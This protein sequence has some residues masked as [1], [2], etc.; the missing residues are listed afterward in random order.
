[1]NSRVSILGLTFGE[2]SA[3]LADLKGHGGGVFALQ[4]KMLQSSVFNFYSNKRLKDHNKDMIKTFIKIIMFCK[5]QLVM[6]PLKQWIPRV[7]S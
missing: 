4:V 7:Y 6:R 3:N 2:H 5:K 1:M